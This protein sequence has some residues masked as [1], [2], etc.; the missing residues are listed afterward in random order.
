MCKVEFE[1]DF[2]SLVKIQLSRGEVDG[3]NWIKYDEPNG[4]GVLVNSEHGRGNHECHT[5][6]MELFL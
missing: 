4:L 6:M 1:L 3:G 5:G 2:E